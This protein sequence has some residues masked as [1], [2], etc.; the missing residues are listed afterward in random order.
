MEWLEFS[1]YVNFQNPDIN[2]HL[3]TQ[4]FTYVDQF[5]DELQDYLDSLDDKEKQEKSKFTACLK[6]FLILNKEKVKQN[7]SE[8]QEK[9]SPQYSIDLERKAI[10]LKGQSDN[11]NGNWKNDLET[12]SS[13]SFTSTFDLPPLDGSNFIASDSNVSIDR[14]DNNDDKSSDSPLWSLTWLGGNNI[15]LVFNDSTKKAQE[16]AKEKALIDEIVELT[17]NLAFPRLCLEAVKE[18]NALYLFNSLSTI[19]CDEETRCMINELKFVRM[20][21]KKELM[22][23]LQ[24]LLKKQPVIGKLTFDQCNFLCDF[25]FPTLPYLKMIEKDLL[26]YDSLKY[27]FMQPMASKF[28]TLS[29]LS[30]NT[31][32]RKHHVMPTSSSSGAF[33]PIPREFAFLN[34]NTPSEPWKQLHSLELTSEP[35]D[36]SKE[37]EENVSIDFESAKFL[38]RRIADCSQLISLSITCQKIAQEAFDPLLE[39]IVQLRALQTLD[40]CNNNLED[41][42]VKKISKILPLLPSLTTLKLSGNRIQDIS[43]LMQGLSNTQLTSLHLEDNLIDNKGA[44]LIAKSVIENPNIRVVT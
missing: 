17:K 35:S 40:F 14:D 7:K 15:S 38:A 31:N 4:L 36:V 8:S 1:Y 2:R 18:E 43:P 19:F 24:T 23:A 11:N 41:D 34:F 42:G 33:D 25:S 6:N 28:P 9:E 12:G 16:I 21:F 29:K 37:D 26:V 10:L 13:T 39:G 32:I 27:F 3:R 30:L 22:E 5:V 44:K 20:T